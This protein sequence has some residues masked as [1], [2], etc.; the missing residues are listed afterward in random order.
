MHP[1]IQMYVRAIEGSCGHVIE[2]L[3]G[4]DGDEIRWH[5]LAS[6]NSLAA[7]AKLT[8]ANTERNVLATFAGQHYDWHRDEE[9]VADGET[10]E[11]LRA[12]WE[13]LRT[14]M[15]E[16]LGAMPAT[17][18]EELCE[19]PRLGRIAGRAVLLQ[20]ARHAAEHLGEAQLTRALLLAR[21]S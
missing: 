2:C 16:C 5:P 1:E 11:S 17:T 10:A 6:A 7:I 19:H 12:T 3:D 13:Q 14:R 20:A 4:L 21:G 8:L 9:F 15:H 18:L